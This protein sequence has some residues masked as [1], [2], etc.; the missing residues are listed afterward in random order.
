MKIHHVAAAAA[1]L[2]VLATAA[3]AS[4]SNITSSRRADFYAPGRHQFYV[5]CADGKDRIAYQAG[6][7]GE[8]AVAK[9]RL[10]ETQADQSGCRP[11]WQGRI[12]S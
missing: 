5:W 1:G 12:N 11:V 6:A 8:D 2:A 10:S 7:S 9:L 4:Q 3:L